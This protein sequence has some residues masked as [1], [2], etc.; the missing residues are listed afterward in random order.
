MES[1]TKIL[2]E[3]QLFD[4]NINWK[5]RLLRIYIIIFGI[6]PKSNHI[7]KQ[8]NIVFLIATIFYW[9]LL[10]KVSYSS[11]STV[12]GKRI[13]AA[14]NVCGVTV[15]CV[16][17]YSTVSYLI[18]LID[19]GNSTGLLYFWLEVFVLGSIMSKSLLFL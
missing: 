12:T 14:L 16:F 1:R 6:I 5:D 18:G 19:A 7:S 8:L 11:I 17:S 4:K 3:D 15:S 9:I 2:K 10:P 13:L